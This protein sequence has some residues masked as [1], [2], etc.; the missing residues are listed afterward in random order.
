M[1]P[2]ADGSRPS[3]GA[4]PRPD[5]ALGPGS[6]AL[7]IL[8]LTLLGLALRLWHLQFQSLWWDEGVSIYLSG[9]GVR[10]LTVAKDFS[11]DLH[12]PGYHLALAGW[13]V[14]LGPSVFSDRLFSVFAGTLTIPL[15]FQFVRRILAAWPHP[16]PLSIGDGEGSRTFSPLHLRWRGA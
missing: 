6:A 11:V 7:V 13:R 8:A 10:A 3:S 14:L 12:P 4:T 2:T 1:K 9:A 15:A 16:P 5:R